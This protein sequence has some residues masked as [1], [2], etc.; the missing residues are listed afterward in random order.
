MTLLRVKQVEYKRER[1]RERERASGLNRFCFS[2]KLEKLKFE[3]LTLRERAWSSFKSRQMFVQQ[4]QSD[5]V[6]GK[7]DREVR[8]PVVLESNVV[9]PSKCEALRE[10]FRNGRQLVELGE[11][12]V[13]EHGEQN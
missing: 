8:R 6:R 5:S 7:T 11:G 10:L 2:F 3:R 12:S 1:E 9:T 4:Q 13:Q